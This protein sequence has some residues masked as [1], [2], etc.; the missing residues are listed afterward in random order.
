[1]LSLFCWRLLH[2]HIENRD[3]E[4]LLL[5][6]GRCEAA[7]YELVYSDNMRWLRKNRCCESRKKPH[8]HHYFLWD[9][10]LLDH[11]GLVRQYRTTLEMGFSGFEIFETFVRPEMRL[12]HTPAGCIA[13]FGLDH[14]PRLP[15]SG[16]A[17]RFENLVDLLI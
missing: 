4:C 13:R 10:G 7:I 2:F 1:M 15:G 6:E 16:L 3:G 9:N 14:S 5:P 8:D 12:P 17:L 11:G